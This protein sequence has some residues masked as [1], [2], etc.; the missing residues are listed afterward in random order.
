MRR[1]EFFGVLGGAAAAWPLA[2]RAQQG[3]RV[4]RI[5]MITGGGGADD[6][7]MKDRVAAFLQGLALLG[8]INGRNV[9]RGGLGNLHRL[10]SGISA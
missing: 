9:L 3:E 7:D 10:I 4:P 5:G 2:A 8:W 1:R 6:P